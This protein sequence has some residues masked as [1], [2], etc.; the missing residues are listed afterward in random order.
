[1]PRIYYRQHV[2]GAS[3]IDVH[4]HVN[5]LEYLRWMQDMATEHTA[6]QG[7]SMARYLKNG[8]SW[9][10]RQHQIEYLRPAFEGDELALVTWVS[11]MEETSSPRHYLFLNLSRRKLI[12]TAQTLWFYVDVASGRPTPIPD[13]LRAAFELV[14]MDD[15]LLQQLRRGGSKAAEALQTLLA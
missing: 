3:S 13:E 1:M 5:N 2:V 8:A 4:G 11:D 9:V 15:P 7:W 12:A 14:E 10:V 6:A